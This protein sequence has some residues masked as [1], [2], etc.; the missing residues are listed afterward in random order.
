V[1]IATVDLNFRPIYAFEYEWAAKNKRAVI[2]FDPLTGE[3]H[4]G[5][6]TWSDQIKSLVNR[7]LLFDITADAFGTIVPGGSI[8]VKLVKA[9][10]DRKK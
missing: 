4:V 1:D 3:M 10:V 5:G 8:A 2:E 6:K 7:D 9:V